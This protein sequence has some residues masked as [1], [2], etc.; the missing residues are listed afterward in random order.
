MPRVV[1]RWT[2]IKVNNV[3]YKSLPMKGL[4]LS[5]TYFSTSHYPT[6]HW[7]RTVFG[8]G[9]VKGIKHGSVTI[10]CACSPQLR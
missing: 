3:L 5:P 10:S 6:I 1:S 9:V 2:N 4:S 8:Y 7:R